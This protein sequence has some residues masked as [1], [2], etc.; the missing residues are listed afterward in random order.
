M[1]LEQEK[2]LGGPKEAVAGRGK[3]LNLAAQ[4]GGGPSGTWIR[5][6]RGPAV[7]WRR[8]PERRHQRQES[9][10]KRR[11]SG[12]FV[13]P[14][15]NENT[16]VTGVSLSCVQENTAHTLLCVSARVCVN[17]LKGR[18]FH[19]NKRH[20]QSSA[21]PGNVRDWQSGVLLQQ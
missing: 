14:A 9:P 6:W 20:S 19:L 21:D 5:T 12:S 1:K 7:S 11:M 13:H 16:S 10:G 15:G 2:L 18:V 4:Q 3:R 8:G 17:R